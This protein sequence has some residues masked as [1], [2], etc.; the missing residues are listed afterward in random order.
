MRTKI[1]DLAQGAR[2]IAAPQWARATEVS[3][4]LSSAEQLVWTK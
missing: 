4:G 2:A 1:S 3:N